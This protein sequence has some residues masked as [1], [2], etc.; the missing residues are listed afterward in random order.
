MYRTHWKKQIPSYDPILCFQ[1]L[2]TCL[3]HWGHRDFFF[4]GEWQE[5]LDRALSTVSQQ[6]GLTGRILTKLLSVSQEICARNCARQNSFSPPQAWFMFLQGHGCEMGYMRRG[7]QKECKLGP[8][9]FQFSFTFPKQSKKDFREYLQ[10]LPM[11]FSLH[12]FCRTCRDGGNP[13]AAPPNAGARSD[14]PP[15]AACFTHGPWAGAGD[16]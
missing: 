4:A 8:Y 5:N 12:S 11:L 6:H 3:L 14:L 15:G 9:P 10:E 13:S 2:R 1:L 7:I 16:H